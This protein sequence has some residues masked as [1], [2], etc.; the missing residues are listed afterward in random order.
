M[1]SLYK[2]SKREVFRDPASYRDYIE[3]KVSRRSG[4]LQQLLR[5]VRIAWELQDP[6]PTKKTHDGKH[7]HF[8]Q[9]FDA[10]APLNGI[11]NAMLH[12]ISMIRRTQQGK[13]IQVVVESKA[14]PTQGSATCRY[15]A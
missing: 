2:S 15:A 10:A 7:P 12:K 5:K 13:E 3:A 11:T 1:V 9:Q 8:D 14:R 6:H 4:S